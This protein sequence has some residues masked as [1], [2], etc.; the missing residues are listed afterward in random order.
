MSDKHE[1]MDDIS[2]IIQADGVDVRD[3]IEVLAHLLGYIGAGY[4]DG[5]EIEDEDAGYKLTVEVFE[6]E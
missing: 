3:V 2:S 1:L 6:N 4:T 5:I